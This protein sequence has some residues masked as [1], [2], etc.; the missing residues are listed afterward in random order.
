MT[1]S[2]V[3]KKHVYAF[4]LVVAIPVFVVILVTSLLFRQEA[5]KIARERSNEAAQLFAQN[6]NT[7]ATNYSFFTS[8]LINDL[9][10]QENARIFTTT[11]DPKIQFEATQG[12][13]SN[14]SWF[15][16]FTSS[17]GSV[18]LFFDEGKY[19]Q[20]GNDTSSP[21]NPEIARALIDSTPDIYSEVYCLDSLKIPGSQTNKPPVMTMVVR[22]S[23]EVASR[24]NISAILISF[25]LLFLEDIAKNTTNNGSE[26]FIV[27][28]DGT[29]LLS[30]NAKKQELEFTSLENEYL[31]KHLV[32]SSSIPTTGWTYHQS[33]PYT[34]FTHSLEIIMRYAYIA[35]GLV[36]VLF[37]TYTRTLFANIIN[38]L[39]SVISRMDRVAGGD[40]SVQVAETG[41]EE[42][43]H[44]EKTFN[45]MVQKI[46]VLTDQIVASQK[47]I[48][49]LENEALRYQL[50]PH[51][52]CN[53]LNSMT[54]MASI[55]KVES[56]KKMSIALTKI[57]QQTLNDNQKVATF[58]KEKEYLESYIYITSIR[59]G[60]R[61]TFETQFD[62]ELKSY[63][64]PTMLL[65][66][67][68]ENSILHGMRGKEGQGSII[69]SAQ[70]HD[71][72][73]IIEVKDTGVGMPP[74]TRDALFQ[75]PSQGKRGFN[76][77]GLYSVRRRL[78]LS[79]PGIGDL[80]VSSEKGKGT[81]I[82][83]TL[84]LLSII[85][86]VQHDASSDS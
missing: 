3:S 61:F 62:E 30:S 12:L 22:P 7:E 74:E 31:K 32:L 15:F 64:L 20:Y 59:F 51:F 77:L 75:A 50:N 6:L 5:I 65:Q 28:R 85:Q 21:L 53:T 82:T 49:R 46:K 44:L 14:V 47:E 86:E 76:R 25:K 54:I 9:N 63:A 42:F 35:L 48:G 37:L 33:I 55:A 13:Q 27:G 70:K 16:R 68:V 38:P 40:F 79:Y 1:H 84:P 24:T 8:A 73:V 78:Q 23:K 56:L 26:Q 57:M 67:L 58:E 83:L 36:L 43:L 29:I 18:F 80:K 19:L 41:S 45:S 17:V 69:V 4:I 10:L 71:D 2:S 60:N 81:T 39:R 72:L 52:I 34:S 11:Q 66:P